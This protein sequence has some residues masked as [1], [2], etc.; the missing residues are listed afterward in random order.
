M[1]QWIEIILLVG[2]GLG[3]GFLLFSYPPIPP[4]GVCDAAGT[5]EECSEWWHD[6]MERP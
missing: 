5:P 1:R 6:I 2:L 3:A 4:P